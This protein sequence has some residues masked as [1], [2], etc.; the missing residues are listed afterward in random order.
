MRAV[1]LCTHAHRDGQIHFVHCR[2]HDRPTA[3]TR[4]I[5]ITTPSPSRS[6]T[7]LVAL[8]PVIEQCAVRGK[9]VA[10]GVECR[11]V[12]DVEGPAGPDKRLKIEV[13][14]RV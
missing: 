13:M 6:P 12:G 10:S 1:V 8:H 11:V 5:G 4:R 3:H 9:L 7:N 14:S 2:T